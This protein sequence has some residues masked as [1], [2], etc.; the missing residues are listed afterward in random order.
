M[1]EN[2]SHSSVTKPPPT[3]LYL[4]GRTEWGRG[5]RWWAVGLAAA[6]GPWRRPGGR[7]QRGGRRR[8][9]G[10]AAAVRR[11][12]GGGRRWTGTEGGWTVPWA[13]QRLSVSETDAAVVQQLGWAC[14]AYLKFKRWRN[15]ILH[16]LCWEVWC[17]NRD[18][19]TVS[20]W[21]LQTRQTSKIVAVSML[22]NM[23]RSHSAWL[24]RLCYLCFVF[25]FW[26]CQLLRL[27]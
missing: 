12:L 14:E 9:G 22:P 17:W 8:G 16:R 6:G 1:F 20:F 15:R 24:N 27:S 3:W 18:L 23:V 21:S 7:L 26:P 2:V 19:G 5:R 11:H 4:L 10:T 25:A 13:L